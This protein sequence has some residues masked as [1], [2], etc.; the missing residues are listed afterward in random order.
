M[1]AACF[2]LQIYQVGVIKKGLHEKGEKITGICDFITLELWALCIFLI[3]PHP[4]KTYFP[5]SPLRH[6][7]EYQ[8]NQRRK[9]KENSFHLK[10]KTLSLRNIQFSKYQHMGKPNTSHLLYRCF[11][12]LLLKRTSVN[13]LKEGL[14][15]SQQTIIHMKFI[16]VINNY[17]HVVFLIYNSSH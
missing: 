10:K 1:S 16:L 12:R 4:T 8:R 6:S 17:L 15:N 9:W 11:Y 5:H 3:R 14:V 7:T 2:L 13:F